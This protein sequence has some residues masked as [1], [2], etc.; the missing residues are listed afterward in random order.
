MAAFLRSWNPEDPQSW[1]RS[2]AWRTLSITTFT[3]TLAFPSWFIA[4]ALAPKL[5][6]LGFALSV[7]QLYWL[8]AMPACPAGSCASSGWFCRRSSAPGGWSP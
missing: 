8:V 4:S 6:N 5:S 2:L 3:L 7:D 1:D